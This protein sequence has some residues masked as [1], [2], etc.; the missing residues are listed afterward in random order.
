MLLPFSGAILGDKSDALPAGDGDGEVLDWGGG[1]CCRCTADVDAPDS[2][3]V[4]LGLLLGIADAE[5]KYGDTRTL[6]PAALGDGTVRA[7]SGVGGGSGAMGGDRPGVC[8]WVAAAAAAAELAMFRPNW[9]AVWMGAPPGGVGEYDTMPRTLL[10]ATV[11]WISGVGVPDGG[12][13]RGSERRGGNLGL[14]ESS[15]STMR[16][17]DDDGK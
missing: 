10:P 1:G 7:A 14:G 15:N 9:L 13:G 4:M 16:C 3:D 8:C 12:N 17:Q 5:M 11:G 2:G 6:G